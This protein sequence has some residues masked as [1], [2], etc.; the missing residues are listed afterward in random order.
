MHLNYPIYYSGIGFVRLSVKLMFL[1]KQIKSST[2]A[3]PKNYAVHKFRVYKIGIDYH[4][5]WEK[6]FFCVKFMGFS[7]H[8]FSLFAFTKMVSTCKES[9]RTFT[10]IFLCYW[11][12]LVCGIINTHPWNWVVVRSNHCCA[13]R[14]HYQE[15]GK[16]QKRINIV[17]LQ[18]HVF[19]ER[20]VTFKLR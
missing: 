9:P 14:V 17:F 4:N 16:Q 19:I 3:W 18:V 6:K 20:T 7:G 11:Q 1:T 12:T 13:Q 2:F 8:I 15:I 10:F 5:S